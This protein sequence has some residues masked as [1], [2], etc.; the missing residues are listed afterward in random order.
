MTG[1][2]FQ[3]VS[4]AEVLSQGSSPERIVDMQNERYITVSIN[5]KGARER[6]IKDGKYPVPFTGYRVSSG[7]FIYSR[8]DAR[9]GAY[10]IVGPELDGFVVSKDFPVFDIDTQRV[11][12]QF[13][14]KSVLGGG[15]L[16]QVRQS[17]FGATNRMRIKEEVLG[18][19]SI[20]LPPLARQEEII[21]ILDRAQ[22]VVDARQ[23]QL[24]KLDELVKARFVEMFGGGCYGEFELGSRMKT[25]SGGTPSKKYP[26][27]FENGT[28]PWLT[29]GEINKGRIRA[30]EH[31]ITKEGLDH[32]SAKL[33][34]KNTVVVAMYGATAG[35]VGIVDY[36]TTTNQAVCCIAPADICD[37]VYLRFALENKKAWMIEQC[38]GGA[39]PNI[40]QG[41]VRKVTIPDASIESQRSFASFVAQVDKSGFG[42]AGGACCPQWPY[43]RH[44]RS[45]RMEGL[46]P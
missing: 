5:G 34:P 24:Q 18:Q 36:E 11:N 30:P 4:L 20:G 39:Q 29:S 26:E 27:Y 2:R 9:N 15:F 19:F 37:P 8:I 44:S 25:V 21:G 22:A 16:S 35:Q 3:T 46:L 17:S 33:V 7:Q 13:L 43:N 45:L 40:S 14:L 1:D 10:G 38:V 41:V 6:V 32:S 28:I 23:A 12:P 31:F 42:I